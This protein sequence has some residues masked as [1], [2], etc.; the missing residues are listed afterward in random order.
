MSISILDTLCPSQI[1]QIQS[2]SSGFP[3]L[4]ADLF[5]LCEQNG[6]V[7]SAAAFIQEDEMTYE[8]YAFTKP[9]FRRQGM[10]SELLDTAI[11]ELPEDVEFTFYTNGKDSDT[12]ETLAALEAELVQEEHMMEIDLSDWTGSHCDLPINMEACD[13]D[14]TVTWS[15]SNP[16]GTVNISVFSS[17]YYLYGFEIK[18]ELRGH[19]HGTVFLGQVL[20]DLTKR[21]PLPMRLQVSG[22]NVP[23]LA[24][25]K[26]TGFQITETLFGY[27]Y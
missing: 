9:E 4:E 14:G 12:L 17:Y 22:D 5:A 11:E 23:A 16:N 7:C 10:F 26:K 13:I 1:V 25:Y 15:Y 6:A 24:L 19:G 18:E 8:C 3:V 20:T 21:N 2:M 27:L